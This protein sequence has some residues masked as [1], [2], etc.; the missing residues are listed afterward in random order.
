[1]ERLM[2]TTAGCALLAALAGSVGAL[3]L[4]EVQRWRRRLSIVSS[5]HLAIRLVGGGLTMLLLG[6]V[7]YGMV[8]VA[9]EEQHGLFFVRFW[10]HCLGLALAVSV[11]ALADLAWVVGWRRGQRR[12][13]RSLTVCRNAARSTRELRGD[14]RLPRPRHPEG[15]RSPVTLVSGGFRERTGA[16]GPQRVGG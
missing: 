16:V 3:C 9:Q 11:V 6:W 7:C 13:L 14:R 4:R 5:G 8:F 15:S 2:L 12:A 10:M 1:M